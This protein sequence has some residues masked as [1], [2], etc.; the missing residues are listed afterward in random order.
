[1]VSENFSGGKRLGY[2]L[3]LLS[4]FMKKAPRGW[5]V[6]GLAC[7][8][9]CS[10]VARAGTQH[11][12]PL[13]SVFFVTVVPLLRPVCCGLSKFK[14]AF[15]VTDINAVHKQ[16]VC[17]HVQLGHLQLL[18]CYRYLN[19]SVNQTLSVGNSLACF[20]ISLGW[21]LSDVLTIQLERT[22]PSR[23][24]LGLWDS[25]SL[26]Q[27]LPSGSCIAPTVRGL[28]WV[29]GRDMAWCIPWLEPSA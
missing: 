25:V 12:P 3:V 4:H 6:E 21:F 14:P 28:P 15:S 9:L 20:S 17:L 22:G 26:R 2:Y 5:G 24:S 29:P 18:S 7:G 1:M 23:P 11:F 10:A 8:H 16:L 13:S 27:R 19:I